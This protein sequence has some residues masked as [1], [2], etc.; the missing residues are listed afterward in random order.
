MTLRWLLRILFV[1]FATVFALMAYDWAIKSGVTGEWNGEIALIYATIAAV[2]SSGIIFFEARFQH[3]L[4]R[5]IVAIAFG[6][7][8]GLFVT[9]LLLAIAIAFVLPSTQGDIIEAFR[10]IQMWVPL[11]MTAI[12]Y[13]AVTV[14]LQTKGDFRFL[15]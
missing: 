5:E 1:S 15:V 12:C 4:A 3:H 6:L 8:A 11:A 13:I 9:G 2:V 10:H 7:A 14:V